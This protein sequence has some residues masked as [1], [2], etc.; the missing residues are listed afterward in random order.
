MFIGHFALGFAA[1]KATPRTSLPTL[2]AAAVFADVL[3]PI[4]LALGIEQVVIDPG[5]TVMTPLDFVSYPWSHSFVMLM[6]WGAVFGGVYFART[7]DARGAVILA[8]LVESHWVLDWITHRPDMP[9][10]PGGPKFGLGMWNSPAIAIT[11]ELAMF[12][13]GV[14]IYARATRARDG[15]GT[16]GFWFLVL[17]FLAAYAAD[18]LAGAAPPSVKGIW[19]G[20]LVAT[21]VTL[22][23]AWWVDRHR[24]P[25]AVA[26]NG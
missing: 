22:L 18:A 7:K 5:N 24:E 23:L 9:I 25:I 2:F 12:A 6:I 1:K 11:V 8:A 15:Q 13:V 21:A 17:L 4:F 10:Y 14:L 3:W 19:I 26:G 20:A 16:W